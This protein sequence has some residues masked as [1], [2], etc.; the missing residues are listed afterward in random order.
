MFTLEDSGEEG[1]R[2]MGVGRAGAPKGLGGE[3]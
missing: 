3:G 2:I 1:E